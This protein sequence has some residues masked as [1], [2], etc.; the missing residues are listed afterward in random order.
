[1]LLNQATLAGVEAGQIDLI[2]RRWVRPTVRAGGTLKTS[3]GLLAIESLKEIDLQRITQQDAR[4]AGFGSPREVQDF[5]NE[6]RGGKDYRIQVRL[7]GPDPRIALRNQGKLTAPE[8]QMLSDRLARLDASSRHG[9]W[10]HRVLQAIEQFPELSAGELAERLQ[11]DKERLKLDVRKLKNL[12][13]TESLHPGYRLSPRGV[14]WLRSL[15][16][17]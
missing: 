1:M 14:A 17:T 10:T 15:R 12:G 6:R 9:A 7:S 13:L 3:I 2:F 4:R 8:R 16:T 5:L 11:C